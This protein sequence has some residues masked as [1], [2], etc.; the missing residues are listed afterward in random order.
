[1]GPYLSHISTDPHIPDQSA[2][3]QQRQK[4][5]SQSSQSK[6]VNPPPITENLLHSACTHPPI[7]PLTGHPAVCGLYLTLT[8]VP[9]PVLVEPVPVCQSRPSF[10]CPSPSLLWPVATLSLRFLP[11]QV[12]L[13]SPLPVS[14]PPPSSTQST[15]L[16]LSIESLPPSLSSCPLSVTSF[17]LETLVLDIDIIVRRLWIV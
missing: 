10:P 11:F 1:M 16:Y 6:P 8:P 12:L 13:S 9:V 17:R 15:S 2:I 5:S 14:L 4:Q 3:S 7:L